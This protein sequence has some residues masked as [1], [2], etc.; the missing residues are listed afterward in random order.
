MDLVLDLVFFRVLIWHIVLGH[1]RL[2]HHVLYEYETYHRCSLLRPS[3]SLSL[4]LSLALSTNSYAATDEQV[5]C[6]TK[7]LKVFSLS[8]GDGWRSKKEEKNV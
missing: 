7:L 2:T 3:L 8:F 1:A 5:R 4:S 6:R